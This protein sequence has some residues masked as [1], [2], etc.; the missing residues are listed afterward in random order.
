MGIE[1]HRATLEAL[2]V[3]GV[4][5]G[6]AATR[7]RPTLEARARYFLRKWR[8]CGQVELCEDDLVQ[9]M[10]FAMWRA[11]DAW[12]SKRSDFVRFV[13][14]QIGRACQRR[15]RHVAGYPD[16]RRS[17]PMKRAK[18]SDVL[19]TI[20]LEGEEHSI[21]A[22][23]LLEARDRVVATAKSAPLLE[24][25][26]LE[27]VFAGLSLEECSKS[28]FADEAARRE[29]RLKTPRAA[30]LKVGVAL[31]AVTGRIAVDSAFDT[32]ANA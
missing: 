27:A 5:F 14:A 9:E 18:S 29:F 7:V 11:V 32:Y 22:A 15:M 13:D 16:P 2:R 30:R 8:W 28:I 23:A 21:D 12:D 3:G 10:L 6:V 20:E 4:S 19:E 26:V 31:V 25:T 24:R 17:V 1:A